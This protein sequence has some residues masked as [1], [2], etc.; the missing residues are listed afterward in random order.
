MKIIEWDFEYLYTYTYVKCLFNKLNAEQWRR[1]SPRSPIVEWK[2]VL[3]PHLP[4][5]AKTLLSKPNID[6]K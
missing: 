3:G 1:G 5:L 6:I 2:W 4:L